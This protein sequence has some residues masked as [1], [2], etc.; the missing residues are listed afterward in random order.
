MHELVRRIMC[1]ALAPALASASAAGAPFG[2]PAG[3]AEKG[4]RS[5]ETCYSHDE[6]DELLRV[7]HELVLDF[8]TDEYTPQLFWVRLRYVAAGESGLSRCYERPGVRAHFTEDSYEYCPADNTIYIGQE[9][10]W[11]FYSGIGDVAP[12]VGLAHEFGHFMQSVADVPPPTTPAESVHHEN[13]A[14]CFAGAWFQHADEAGLVERPDDLEDIDE[15]LELIGSS[16]DDPGR[17]H[18]T[19]AERK[20]AFEQGWGGGLEACNQYYPATPVKS[21]EERE[22]WRSLRWTLRHPG[23]DPVAP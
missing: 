5:L 13:Q 14:D 21:Q 7:A 12:I 3:A 9:E 11:R 20:Q 6:M 15:I 10:L 16:E 18:G 2:A 19:A 17:T 23:L 22:R 4:C 8:A 1:A